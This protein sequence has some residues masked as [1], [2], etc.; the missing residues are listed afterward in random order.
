M[1]KTGR[2][3]HQLGNHIDKWKK[4]IMKG[5]VRKRKTP[6]SSDTGRLEKEYL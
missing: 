4:K 5:L 3:R 6:D 1:L 2:T